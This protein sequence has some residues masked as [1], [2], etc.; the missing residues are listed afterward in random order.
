MILI[1]IKTF[2]G[3]VIYISP[4]AEFTPKN[5]ETKDERAKLVYAVKIHIH[6]PDFDLKDGMPADAV[7]N[8]Q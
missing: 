7:I 4:D 3:K 8:L 1:K 5:I 2:T 6:N